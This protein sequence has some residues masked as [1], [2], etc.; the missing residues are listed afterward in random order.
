MRR[1]ISILTLLASLVGL[2]A[3][4][5]FLTVPGSAANASSNDS[6]APTRAAYVRPVTADGHPARGWKVHNE[7]GSVSCDGAS[8]SAVNPGI[9]SCYPTAFA[10]R[11]CWKT[12]N[13]TVLCVRDA[14]EKKL[15][16]I[17]YT[18]AFPKVQARA[19]PTPMNLV[20]N[21]GH[22]CL[23][24][25][26]GAWS[27]PAQH[28]NWVGFDSCTRKA[29]V[30]A[31][32]SSTD[33]INRRHARWTVNLWRYGKDPNGDHLVRRSVRKAYYVG[34]APASGS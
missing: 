1:P 3:V 29:D 10:L 24:R 12:K 26:G 23:I 18:G 20:L 16:R 17:R 15:T 21:D 33:G 31:R 11:A 7:R 34:T 9:V 2:A 6:G 14:Q 8:P 27:S 30:F 4:T 25:V 19:E 22:T 28:P 13:H 32:G 5:A